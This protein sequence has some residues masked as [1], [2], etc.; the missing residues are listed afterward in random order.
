MSSWSTNESISA[1]QL[2]KA[3]SKRHA[4]EN[5]LNWPKISVIFTC[6]LILFHNFCQEDDSWYVVPP[7]DIDELWQ[8]HLGPRGGGALPLW[9]WCGYKAPKTAL[10]SRKRPHIFWWNVGSSIALTQ[11]PPIRQIILTIL[12]I[13]LLLQIPA[14]EALTERSKVYELSY[15]M[16]LIWNQNLAYH[17]MTPHFWRLCSHRMPKPLEVWALHPYPFDIGVPPPPG[18]PYID[19]RSNHKVSNWAYFFFLFLNGGRAGGTQLWKWWHDLFCQ[20]FLNMEGPRGHS[21]LE[22]MGWSD[23]LETIPFN[24]GLNFDC[25]WKF[26]NFTKFH[27]SH[28]LSGQKCM[29][30]TLSQIFNTTQNFWILSISSFED[31]EW[32]KLSLD[33]NLKCDWKYLNFTEFYQISSF[34]CPEWSKMSVFDKFSTWLKIFWFFPISSFAGS[35]WLKISFYIKFTTWLKISGFC[36]ISYPSHV[37]S[38][39]KSQFWAK[40]STWLKISGFCQISTFA[41]S[42]WSKISFWAKFT[43]RLKISW[44][45][46]ISYP[47]HVLSC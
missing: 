9:R 4:S 16:P 5:L 40:F 10:L 27:S 18:R 24:F 12:T 43:T 6:I 42:E 33:Q 3:K 19:N 22:V 47:S 46:Q 8:I 29:F 44:F 20:F 31:S 34:A 2:N 15:P 41:G 14:F 30:L 13:F 26:L 32:S 17:P 1:D 35:E 23:R 28:V 7:C 36:Q 25:G 45:C 37:L 21:T 38:G 11:R 39:Q